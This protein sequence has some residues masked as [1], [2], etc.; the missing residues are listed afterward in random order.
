MQTVDE[1]ERRFLIVSYVGQAVVQ[2]RRNRAE[3]AREA[4]RTL[5]ELLAH[6]WNLRRALA[7]LQGA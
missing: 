4:M 1:Q 2:M 3:D 5:D 6:A 7:R